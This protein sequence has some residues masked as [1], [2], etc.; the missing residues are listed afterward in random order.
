MT[1]NIQL[2]QKLRRC[3]FNADQVAISKEDTARVKKMRSLLDVVILDERDLNHKEIE[4]L[5]TLEKDK[6]FKL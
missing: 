3:W 2:I 5:K 4:F 6:N 1:K